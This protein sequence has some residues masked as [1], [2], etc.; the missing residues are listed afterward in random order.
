[1]VE[2]VADLGVDEIGRDG[3]VALVGGRGGL[4]GEAGLVD[5][6]EIVVE[7]ADPRRAGEPQ[8]GGEQASVA[9]LDRA[10]AG[11]RIL[12]VEAVAVELERAAED[13]GEGIGGAEE[14]QVQALAV[15][16]DAVVEDAVDVVGQ[17]RVELCR[18]LGD[19]GGQA[20]R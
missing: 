1:M 5:P 9:G 7:F 16:L 15:E 14:L 2:G 6:L 18:I 19:G 3:E 20:A 4:A 13:V 10:Q 8:A 17:P 11:A 12:L